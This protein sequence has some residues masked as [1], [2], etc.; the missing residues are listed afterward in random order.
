M[1]ATLLERKEMPIEVADAV[2]ARRA[3][4]TSRWAVAGVV[5]AFASFVIWGVLSLATP[6][7]AVIAVVFGLIAKMR[8]RRNPQRIAG[9]TW[10]GI[11]IVGGFL[12]L[13]LLT[14]LLYFSKA[15]DRERYQYANFG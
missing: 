11:A 12:N 7:P 2:A 5:V 8:I 10:A 13:L 6:L 14:G 4:R 1:I 9:R 15:A 3:P